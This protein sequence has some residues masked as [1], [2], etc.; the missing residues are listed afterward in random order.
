MA[1]RKIDLRISFF[2]RFALT[3]VALV[4]PI[5]L[6]CCRPGK[7]TANTVT[8]RPLADSAAVDPTTQP[9]DYIVQAGDVLEL[10]FFYQPELN[11]SLTV[12][13]DGKIS[14]QLVDEISV[15]GRTIPDVR[16]EL[17]QK[18][19]KVLRNPEV[20]VAVKEIAEQRIFVGGEV[21]TPGAMPLKGRVTALEAIMQA[22]GMK[23]TAETR[24]VVILRNQGTEQPLFLTLNLDSELTTANESHDILLHA[25]DVVFVPKTNVTGAD[26]FVDQYFDKLIFGTRSVGAFYDLNTVKQ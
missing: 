2:K 16:M 21:N 24:Q 5:T 23:G 15:A 22:G 20:G 8:V 1:T 9:A 6:T 11:D 18:Y 7:D 12:R 26:E 17:Q 25:M 14:P 3:L 19:A 13:P 4:L 10:K